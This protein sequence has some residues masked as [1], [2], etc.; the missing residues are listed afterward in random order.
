LT[1]AFAEDHP[2]AR[3]IITKSPPDLRPHPLNKELYGLPTA[4]DQYEN[5][6]FAMKHGGF[7]WEE[8]PLLITPDGRVISGVT[9]WAAAK[10]VGLA[11]VPCVVFVPKAP[12]GT[13]SAELEIEAKLIQENRYRTKTRLMVAR[14]Q[15][16]LVEIEKLKARGRMAAGSDGGESK[17]VD[18]VG[19]DFKTSGKTVQRNLKVLA[20]IEEAEAA[21]DRKKADRLTELLEHGKVGVALELL[22]GKEKAKKPPKVEAPRTLNDHSSKAYSEFYE[23]C[24][25]AEVPAEIELLESMQERMGQ[26]LRTARG[27]V[28]PSEDEP[29]AEGA[30]AGGQPPALADHPTVKKVLAMLSEC[31]SEMRK[32]VVSRADSLVMEHLSTMQRLLSDGKEGYYGPRGGH[33]PRK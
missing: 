29:E 33:K 18:R 1:H 27:R 20:G 13:E 9:R 14:E 16:R 17:S 24:A 6:K 11:E 25:K 4:S 10:A 21:G 30:G 8:H 28:S 23:G 3:K 15:R 32:S 7:D 31:M 19:A 26:A 12:A 22:D 2:M 5:F